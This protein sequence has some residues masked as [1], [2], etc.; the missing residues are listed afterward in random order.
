MFPTRL[1]LLSP[2]KRAALHRLIY[3]QFLRGLL[4]IMLLVL[5]VSGIALLGGRSVL[6]DYF[7]ELAVEIAAI[8]NQQA[9]TNQQVKLINRVLSQ[10]ENLQKAY[11]LW[12]PIMADLAN[13]IPDNITLTGLDLNIKKKAATFTGF[14]ADRDALLNLQ[15]QL[16]SLPRIAKVDIPLSQLTEKKDISFSITATLK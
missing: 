2:A 15:K 1:N 4:E 6:Q 5:S 14:S 8:S 3:L 11:T 7:D 13:A 9:D 12:T 16:E 10:T